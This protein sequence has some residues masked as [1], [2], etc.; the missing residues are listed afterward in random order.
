MLTSAQWK[1]PTWHHLH[2]WRMG[3]CERACVRIR[4]ASK[5]ILYVNLAIFLISFI[6]VLLHKNLLIFKIGGP[7]PAVLREVMLDLVDTGRCRHV[8]QGLRPKPQPLTVVCAG[9]ERGS[10]DACQVHESFTCLIRAKIMDF[11]NSI[12]GKSR[13]GPSNITWRWKLSPVMPRVFMA[14]SQCPN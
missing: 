12:V 1:V 4:K 2:C 10:R 14:E 13:E 9:P 5:I 8:L 6:V 7:L 11:S 3:T